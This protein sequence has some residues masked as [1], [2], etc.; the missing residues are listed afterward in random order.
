MPLRSRRAVPGFRYATERLHGDG[1]RARH[2]VRGDE[3][4]TRLQ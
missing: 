1:A 3:L 2:T 4:V